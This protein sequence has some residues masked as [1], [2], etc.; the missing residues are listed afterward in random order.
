MRAADELE[1][2]QIV[3]AHFPTMAKP[4][5][6][7]PV[8]LLQ[9]LSAAAKLSVGGDTRPLGVRECVTFAARLA[10]H[11]P[12]LPGAKRVALSVLDAIDICAAHLAKRS[13][14]QGLKLKNVRHSRISHF[15]DSIL[16]ERYV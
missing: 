13:D 9:V 7:I 10:R 16:L 3:T 4:I 11:P 2:E 5:R 6:R 1:L 15:F 8:Q 14:R 12:N